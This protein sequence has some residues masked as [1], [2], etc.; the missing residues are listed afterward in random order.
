MTQREDELKLRREEREAR[1][2]D[3]EK[4]KKT[5]EAAEKRWAQKK[6]LKKKD[7]QDKEAAKKDITGREELLEGARAEHEKERREL[8]EVLRERDILNKKLVLASGATEKQLGQVKQCSKRSGQNTNATQR[9]CR[10]QVIKADVMNTRCARQLEW[11]ERL[12]SK[13]GGM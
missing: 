5:T 3:L 12:V 9:W 7:E 6:E 4:I 13:V 2:V 1:H 10:D 11:F 8:D